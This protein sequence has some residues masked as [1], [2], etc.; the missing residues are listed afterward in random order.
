MLVWLQ[1]EEMKD[2]WRVAFLKRCLNHGF[3]FHVSFSSTFRCKYPA[4]DPYFQP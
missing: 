2:I 1:K 3:I 4:T